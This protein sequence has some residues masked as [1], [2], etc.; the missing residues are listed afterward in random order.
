MLTSNNNQGR[1]PIIRLLN[2]RLADTID[3]LYQAKQ[4]HW[5]VTGREFY[6]LHELFEKIS[7]E[8]REHVDDIAERVA[9]LGGEA[10]GTV[11]MAAEHS[12][13]P[14]YP[15]QLSGADAHL[16]ALSNALGASAISMRD[17]ID[18]SS[19]LGDEVTA[20]IFVGAT[21]AIDKLLWMVRAHSSRQPASWTEQASRDRD[22]EPAT[23]TR[24]RH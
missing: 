14:D 19:R 16:E 15:R 23:T 2:A 7:N 21:R 9:Q 6:A 8:L 17:A 22:R 4:A 12:S 5:N 18:E 13:L 20:D 1:D 3:L 10:Q 24:S 11:K